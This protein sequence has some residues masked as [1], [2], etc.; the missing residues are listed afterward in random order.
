MESFEYT[1]LTLTV[2]KADDDKH[3]VEVFQLNPFSM[4]SFGTY[5][6]LVVWLESEVV[7]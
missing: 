5:N 6:M 3:R 7:G 1:K 4:E 2:H